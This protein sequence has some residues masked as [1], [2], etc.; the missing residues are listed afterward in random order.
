[1]TPTLLQK[2]KKLAQ[3]YYQSYGLMCEIGRK[4]YRVQQDKTHRADAV[5]ERIGLEEGT[6]RI[7]ER[8]LHKPPKFLLTAEISKKGQKS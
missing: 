5:V 1:M 6:Y 7:F 4:G 3:R 8:G 2:A